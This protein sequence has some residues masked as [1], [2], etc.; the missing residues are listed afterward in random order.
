MDL[1]RETYGESSSREVS[2]FPS[3]TDGSPLPGFSGG[4]GNAVRLAREGKLS[5]LLFVSEISRWDA[6]SRQFVR[7]SPISN[8][9]GPMTAPLFGKDEFNGL[10]PLLVRRIWAS[11]DGFC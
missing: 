5:G 11:L 7:A 2:H 10:F 1:L 8:S 6:D 4:Y 9:S 3:R